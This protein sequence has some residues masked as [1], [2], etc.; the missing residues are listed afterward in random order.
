MNELIMTK[1][2]APKTVKKQKRVLRTSKQKISKKEMQE[3]INELVSLLFEEK[4]KK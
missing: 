3:R 1:K 2:K 4:S